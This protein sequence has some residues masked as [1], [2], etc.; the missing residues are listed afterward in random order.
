MER[1]TRQTTRHQRWHKSR[2]AGQALHP[3]AP[4]VTSAGEQKPRVADTGCAGVGDERQGSAGG[5][6]IHQT[7]HHSMLVVRMKSAQRRGDPV[8]IEQAFAGS[9]IFRQHHRHL[10][11]DAQGAQ[12]DVFEVADGGGDDV[13][14]GA[15]C[16]IY[17]CFSS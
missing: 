15:E 13:E 2:S 9:R 6:F 4:A 16:G 12:G 1:I 11:Q 5:Q 8:M 10:F 3:N 17:A 7:L 14:H